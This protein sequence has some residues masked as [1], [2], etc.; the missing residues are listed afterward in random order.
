MKRLMGLDLG[1]KTLGIALS[2][3]AQI[4][5]S[6]YENFT[7]KSRDFLSA[8][9]RVVALCELF[10]IEEIALGNPIM[11]SGEESVRSR[12]SHKFKKMILSLNPELKITLVDERLTTI[13]ASVILK[14][15][16]YQANQGRVVDQVAA[17]LIL[18]SF[19][20][21]KKSPN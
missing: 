19:M 14:E 10:K 18:E 6:P 8:A 15:N 4:I 3:A 11:P 9:K 1:N 17:A 13:E 5:A 7:F 21:R 16:K 12:V 20:K 2:D